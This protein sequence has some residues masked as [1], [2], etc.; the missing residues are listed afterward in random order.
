VAKLVV[1]LRMRRRDSLSLR[2]GY[3]QCPA[4]ASLFSSSPRPR[5]S[6]SRSERGSEERAVCITKARG[7]WWCSRGRRRCW[8]HPWSA[9]AARCNTYSIRATNL[10]EQP[11]VNSHLSAGLPAQ[12]G[13][14]FTS[15]RKRIMP[16]LCPSPTGT[17]TSSSL[18]TFQTN[19]FV[20]RQ[21]R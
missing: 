5:G 18:L 8:L 6:S 14:Q 4:A 19:G 20:E 13:P 21:G 3:R 12:D 15:T 2:R 1:W 16:A 9:L 10:W 7:S 11:L 17:A